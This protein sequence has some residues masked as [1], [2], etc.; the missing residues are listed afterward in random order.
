MNGRRYDIDWLRVFATYLLF[1]F[2]VGKVYDAFPDYPIRSLDLSMP[3]AY[4]TSFVHLWHMPLFFALAG[5][6]LYGSISRRGAREVLKERFKRIFIPFVV[7]TAT[8]CLV[9]GYFERVQ[10]VRWI[11]EHHLEASS[12]AASFHPRVLEPGMNMT[13]LQYVPKFFTSLDYFSWS[14]LW[15]LIYLF[16]FTLVWFPL[17]R[18]L[19]ARAGTLTLRR[20]WHI[21]RPIPAL[22]LMQGV[23]RIW[24]P[25]YQNLFND[26]GNFTYYSAAMILGFLIASQPAI[27]DAIQREWRRATV[28]GLIAAAWCLWTIAHR[29]VWPDDL[30]HISYYASSTVAGYTLIIGLLGFARSCLNVRTRALDYLAES[31]LPVYIL[32]Q[33]CIVIPGWFIMHRALGLPTRFAL[34]LAVSFALCLATYHLL[35]RP[36][37]I[38]RRL[39]GM[40]PLRGE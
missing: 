3:L 16:T 36:F 17:F 40:K 20:S 7:G 35:V 9:I 18:R 19:S 37:S 25:G 24:W 33:A 2:H 22:F 6:S 30:R 39:L 5:W 13:F 34:L 29:E 12:A 27:G 11:V 26:W 4:F 31:A 38:P 14:H 10:M 28:V 23:L 32:H 1:P 8:L 15:F 21:Y